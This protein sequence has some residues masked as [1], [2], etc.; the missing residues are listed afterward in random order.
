MS[1]FRVV[2]KWCGNEFVFDDLTD[3]TTLAALKQR[4]AEKTGVRPERQKLLGLKIKSKTEKSDESRK[5]IDCGARNG[6][7]IMM[8]GTREEDMVDVMSPPEEL[9]AKVIDDFDVEEDEVEIQH[10]PE[11]LQKIDHRVREYK[12]NVLNESRPGKKLLVLDVDYT[13]FDHKSTAETV[14]V[15]SRPHLH[16]FLSGVYE[17]YDIAIW[18]ATNMKW[19]EVKMKELGVLTNANYKVVFMLCSLATITVHL[20]EKG[21]VDVKP[22]A[23]I[24]GKFPQYTS[25]N[26]LMVDDLRRNF[27]MNPSNGIKIRP[28]R[29]AHF[30][31][32]RDSELLKLLSYLRSISDV[33][34]VTQI[35]HN[36]WEKKS[37]RS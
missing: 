14:G 3:V 2:V 18:S 4:I 6:M 22:L 11:Y 29:D 32:S 27:L 1:S 34:D 7:K 8:M 13:L 19:V 10:R 35:S 33:N 30:N 12:I 24:W 21:F 17:H 31:Q 26:T 15:L 9:Q 20:P 16:E 25:T 37:C 23:V 28:F 36:K 5:L